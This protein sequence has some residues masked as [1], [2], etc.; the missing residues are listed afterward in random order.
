MRNIMNKIEYASKHETVRKISKK[1][2]E[3]Q[4]SFANVFLLFL[5][6]IDVQL[7]NWPFYQQQMRGNWT[8][9]YENEHNL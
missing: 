4:L 6:E 9:K 7:Q 3:C 2:L 1:V 5:K 8:K